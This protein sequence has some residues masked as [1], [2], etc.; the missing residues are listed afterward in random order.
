MSHD[1]IE[2]ACAALAHGKR[3]NRRAC[4]PPAWPMPARTFGRSSAGDLC[5][6]A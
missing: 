6:D 4:C 3:A 2:R 5:R 1:D